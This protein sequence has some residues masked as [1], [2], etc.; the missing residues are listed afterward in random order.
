MQATAA[1]PMPVAMFKLRPRFDK[2]ARGQAR[3]GNADPGP[4]MERYDRDGEQGQLENEI[5]AVVQ[6]PALEA[7]QPREV[8]QDRGA[9][10]GQNRSVEPR[11][12]RGKVE[13]GFHPARPGKTGPAGSPR[14]TT[15]GTPLARG[16]RPSG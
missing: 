8:D 16:S 11:P 5:E 13:P 6:P 2:F 1:K 12:D 10:K 4:A 7:R 15:A 14:S 3:P 9:R